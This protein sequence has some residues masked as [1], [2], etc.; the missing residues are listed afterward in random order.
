MR[1]IAVVAAREYLSAV[2][3]KAFIITVVAMPVLMVGGIFIQYLLHRGLDV[4]DKRL[5]VLDYT[6]VL[7]DAL[8][9]ECEIRNATD[10]FEDEEDSETGERRQT[11]AKFVLEQV[12]PDDT[13]PEAVRLNLSDRVRNEEFFAFVEIQAD[14]LDP[15]DP[16]A[17]TVKYYSR[18][19][20]YR[21][22]RRWLTK[23]L[24]RSV[25]AWRFKQSGLDRE[26]VGWALQFT[27]VANLELVTLD[28]LTGEII[29]GKEV[30]KIRNMLVPAVLVMLLF[31]VIMTAASP[32]I[33]SA[34]EEKTLRIAEVLLAS[35]TP[36]EW[37]MGKLF[38]VVGVSLTITVV[39]LGGGYAA[40]VYQ[41]FSHYI[42]YDLLGWFLAYQVLSVFMFGGMFA[43]IGAACTD[44]RE[45][46]SAIMPIMIV[47]V[48]PMMVWMNVAQE[49][50]STFST[51]ISLFPP[52]TPAL[53]LV[54]QAVPPGVPLWQPVLG[55]ALVALTTLL[56]VFVASRIFRVG[57]LMQGKGAKLG[58]MLRWVVKG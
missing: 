14:A 19:P 29:E 23:A 28:E 5:A 30:D 32:L 21:D 26:K 2:K 51:L 15:S 47:I 55:M 10:I 3:S 46:Q 42:P 17:A 13:D 24:T 50:T 36:F 37:M 20:T 57:I 56:S 53:M 9:A 38:G 33:Q 44:H 48:M 45:A 58:E 49:P 52:A 41:G 12:S 35:V 16:Q 1:K 54:R 27:T 43:A 7:Y 11:E 31:A 6:G 34:L 39:Y 18:T 8:Q 40:A 4:R 25:Q 22:L